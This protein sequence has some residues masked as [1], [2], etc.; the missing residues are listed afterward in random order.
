MTKVIGVRF[1]KAGKVYYFSP[2]DADIK[3]GQHVIVETARGVEYGH[4]VLGSH[5]VDDKKVIQPLKPVIRMATAA[6]EEIERRNKEKEKEAFKICLEKIKKHELDM[7]LIDTEYTFYNNKVLFYFTADG[8][9][10]FRDL[11]KDL[12]SVFKTRIELRQIGV[13]DETKIV[14]GIGICGRPLCC[15]SYLSEFIPVSIKMAKEQNLSLNPTKISG[16]C[17]RLMCC[18]KYEEETYEELNG[19]LPNIGDYVTTD[20]GLKGEVHSVSILRQL[21][22]VVVTVNGDEKEIR[23]Y[24][25]DQLKFR[26]KRKKE[27]MSISDAEL[28]QLEALEKKEG[29]SKLDDN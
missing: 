15:A 20:D 29:K 28:K 1:R 9:I 10:D 12:A 26:P 5:E 23:E 17:G 21:V 24:K 16:V 18:L 11:V 25:V 4:V 14:G 3:A 27:K 2:G 22:K 8:R 19:R 13:R 7:K 6:D